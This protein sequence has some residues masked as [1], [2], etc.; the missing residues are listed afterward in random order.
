MRNAA[1]LAAA[2]GALVTLVTLSLNTVSTLDVTYANSELRAAVE[3]TQALI[4][5][6]V[7][8]LLYLRFRRTRQRNDLL[9]V[10]GIGLLGA[11]NVLLV[12]ALVAG[13]S[14]RSSAFD[15]WAPLLTRVI[16]ALAIVAA[17][18]ARPRRLTVGRVVPAILAAHVLSLVAVSGVIFAFRGTLPLGV[19]IPPDLLRSGRPS[20]EGHPVILGAQLV[21]MALFWLGAGGYVYRW[22]DDP[23]P[24]TTALVAGFVLAGFSRLSFSLNPTLY[25]DIVDTGDLLRL[26]SYLVFLVGAGREISNHWQGLARLAVSEERERT[27]RELHDGLVQELSFIRSQTADLTSGRATPAVLQQVA[28]AADR[29]LEE[30]RR[31]VRVLS[32][33]TTEDVL[34]ALRRAAEEIAVRAGVTVHY[35]SKRLPHLSPAAVASLSRIVREACSNAVRHGHAKRIVVCAEP[36]DGGWIRVTVC[37]DGEGFDPEAVAGKGGFGLRSMEERAAAL[38]GRCKVSS[39]QGGGTSVEVVT[40]VR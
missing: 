10:Y 17:G 23:G 38:G 21:L 5:F 32:G 29:A 36:W 26:G 33:E 13:R 8:H 7:T 35:E 37:D 11:A 12:C 16:A 31:A 19:E 3:A 34:V 4:G 24:L 22:R 14:P 30:S 25:T 9:L 27:A 18:W 39:T 40:P 28:S 2:S 15:T 20:V 1:L 6:L